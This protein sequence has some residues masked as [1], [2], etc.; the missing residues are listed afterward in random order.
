MTVK[1]SGKKNQKQILTDP[2]LDN[3]QPPA[4]FN[5]K[6][7]EMIELLKKVGIPSFPKSKT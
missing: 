5:K 4:V 7:D 6:R 3:L 2:S 1:I